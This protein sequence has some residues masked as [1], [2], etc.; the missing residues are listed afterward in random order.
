MKSKYELIKKLDALNI[1]FFERRILLSL[2]SKINKVRTDREELL[3]FISMG[4]DIEIYN[5]EK[6]FE[7]R[8]DIKGMIV[9]YNSNEKMFDILSSVEMLMEKFS[10]KVLFVVSASEK[11]YITIC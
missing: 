11:K 1:P 6:E 9:I 2:E 5:N 10:T 3:E 7:N 8:V 4:S